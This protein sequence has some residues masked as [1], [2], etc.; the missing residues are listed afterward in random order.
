MADTEGD[1]DMWRIDKRISLDHLFTPVLWVGTLVYVIAVYGSQIDF[2]KE[3]QVESREFIKESNTKNAQLTDRM[4]KLETE[5]NNLQDLVKIQSTV[6]N[7]IDRK[8]PTFKE[9]DEM[10]GA[11]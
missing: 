5:F 10:D 4:T 1:S 11:K 8:L 2:M 3:R 6:L 9:L 7:R